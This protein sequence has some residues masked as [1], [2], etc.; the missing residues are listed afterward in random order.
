MKIDSINVRQTV[1]LARGIQEG[2][3]KVLPWQETLQD[4]VSLP[5]RRFS[6]VKYDRNPEHPILIT[7]TPTVAHLLFLPVINR[8]N[9]LKHIP[10][11]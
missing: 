3:S 10:L 7:S 1:L 8:L 11:V 6:G 4:L 2:K 5:F 9:A